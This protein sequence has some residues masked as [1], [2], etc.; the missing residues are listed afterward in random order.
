MSAEGVISETIVVPIASGGIA[1]R[2]TESYKPA[3]PET[4]GST[5]KRIKYRVE[6]VEI[7]TG[8]VLHR[9]ETKGLNLDD[10]AAL[11]GAE[12]VFELVTT[13]RTGQKTSGDETLTRVPHA[14][15]AASVSMHILSGAIIHALRSVVQYYPGQD[16]SSDVVKVASPYAILVHHYDELMEYRE[17]VKSG[18]AEE[19][20]YREKDAYEHLGI[21]KDF[22]DGHVMPAVEAERARNK[23]GAYTSDMYWVMMKPGTTFVAQWLEDDE[24]YAGVVHS[25]TGGSFEK[26]S[27]G[28]NTYYWTLQYNGTFV[29]R[30]LQSSHM[31]K[32]DGENNMVTTPL[33]LDNLSSNEGVEDLIGYGKLYWSHLRKQCRYYKGKT[34]EYPHTEVDGLVMVD[35]DAY[36]E[37]FPAKRPV[38]LGNSS[39]KHKKTTVFENYESLP[40]KTR[41]ELDSE[42]LHVKGLGEPNFEENMINQLVMDEKRVNTLKAL[43]KSFIRV[44]KFG[45]TSDKEPWS[46]DF[47]KGKGNGLIFLLHG[48]PGTG[49]TCT[50]E[51]IAAFTSRPLMVLTSSDIGT[52]PTDVE[53]N[54]TEHFKRARSWGAVLLIDEADVFMERRTT[55]D[56][57]RNSLVAGFLRALEFYDGILFLTTNRIGSFD[58]A[59]I[60]RIHFLLGYP[61]FTDESRRK[62]WQTFISKLQRERGDYIRLNIDAKEYLDGKELRS[63]KWNGREIRNAF[64][65]AVALAEY[66]ATKDSEGKIIMNDSH[67]RSVVEMSRDFKEY[68][69]DLHRG[70]EGK[71]AERRFERL[72]K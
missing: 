5:Q 39:D 25:L 55:A 51:C 17:R 3:A 56:L 23:R 46:A 32:F 30:V 68:L 33:D 59:F 6:Y 15:S 22:L 37:A 65:T 31:E 28:W 53:R 69:K 40:P 8:N 20:C 34:K 61:E 10:E 35:M 66:E 72:D 63:V 38:V 16:L 9:H 52:E 64:Q 18:V 12:T 48:S 60:S 19:K 1:E 50:A 42:L 43:A 71:R 14:G 47:V 62:V 24:H 13:I 54:L 29:E 4:P 44:N 45:E 27:V 41:D 21:L 11:G 26:P 49:K 57:T 58:D 7:T 2:I 67:L 36:L 70:D